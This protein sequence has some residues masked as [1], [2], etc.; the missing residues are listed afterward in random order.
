MAEQPEYAEA[1]ELMIDI[2]R[3][4]QAIADAA[5]AAADCE[6]Q[7]HARALNDWTIKQ[8]EW[9][10]REALDHGAAGDLEKQNK[11]LASLIEGVAVGF[12]SSIQVICGPRAATDLFVP[13]GNR[14]VDRLNDLMGAAIETYRAMDALAT[15]ADGD[16]AVQ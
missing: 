3:K 14:L 9:A 5:E 13:L 8:V 10:I 12:V 2:I 11:A 6:Q 1:R 15:I 4:M 7:T 16:T